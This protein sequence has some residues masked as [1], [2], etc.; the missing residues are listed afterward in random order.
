MDGERSRGVAKKKKKDLINNNDWS[1]NI[2]L[3]PLSRTEWNDKD[4]N[5]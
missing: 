5:F 3:Q 4:L 2:I 1:E